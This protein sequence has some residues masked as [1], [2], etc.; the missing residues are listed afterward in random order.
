[1]KK[2]TLLLT[3]L[4]LSSTLLLAQRYVS[5]MF[6]DVSITSD[7]TYG[8]NATVLFVGQVGEAIPQEL[9]MDIY[10]PMG[11]T[12]TSRPAVLIFHTGNFLPPTFNGGCGGTN[13]DADV[14]ELATRLAKMG[15]VACVT[16][17]RLGW[18]PT[19]S[20]QTIRTFTIINAAYR[21]VQDSRTAVKFLK[22]TEAEDANPYG[23][24]PNRIAMWG[25]GTGAYVTYGSSTLNTVQD[26]WIP[27]FTTPL[28]P[29]VHPAI[30]GDLDAN[31]VGIA[32]A[33]YDPFPEGDT[34]C[35]PNHVGYDGSFQLGVQMGGACGDTAWVT[36]GD[37][38]MISTHVTTDPFAP[39]NFGI[40]N[41]P[42]P[43]NLPVVEVMGAGTIIPL[44]VD[45]GV[46][47]VF[48]ET[49]LDDISA[50][51]SGENGGIQG[52]FPIYSNDPQE[53]ATWNFAYSAEPY[54]VPGSDCPTDQAAATMVMDSVISYFAPRACL[55]L[56]LGCDLDGIVGTNDLLDDNQVGLTV[57]PNP[58]SDY[59][60][61]TTKSAPI[62]HLY[63]FDMMGK[64]IGV[65]N[66]INSN[67]FNLN[68]GSLPQGMYMALLSFEE[69]YISKKVVFGQ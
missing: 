42:P 45:R 37:V 10:E 8:V 44:A 65:H 54:G 22:K 13:A 61:F 56:D 11:D 40:V 52:L 4:L 3:V 9:K 66:S 19:N 20:D 1:M 25:F 18:D 63:I 35:Y 34:L 47:N 39:Y 60:N 49:Y 16:D 29:M 55:A 50:Y 67:N 27:K 24:D 36:A 48:N 23:I 26:T 57:A 7:V 59:I 2:I 15:Y 32:P 41:V 46:N 62:Q 68:R 51:V 21:G 6:T 69:G 28:G 58:G 30:N 38:P 31:T 33:G 64:L 17:Y 43:I 5:E 14:V 12:E 53:S